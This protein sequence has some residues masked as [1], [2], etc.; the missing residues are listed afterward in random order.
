M[1]QIYVNLEELKASQ[2]DLRKT[3]TRDEEET[4]SCCS[5]KAVL[6]FLGVLSLVLLTA[7][8]TVS[9]LY[10][11]DHNQLTSYL[12]NQTAER[13]QLMIKNYN[14]TQERDQLETL[15]ETLG[16][17]SGSCPDG[18]RKFGCRCYFLSAVMTSWQQSRQ[19]CLNYGADLVIINCWDKMVFLNNLGASLK[20]WIGLR[21]ITVSY[22]SAWQWTDGTSPRT[23]YWKYGNPNVNYNYQSCAAFNSFTSSFSQKTFTTTTKS[24]SSE[25]CFQS[26]TFVCEKQSTCLS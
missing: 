6:V 12:T 4:G 20:F 13:Q 16:K 26:L 14:L 18:W 3:E 25:S 21:Q 22:S 8:I 2:G 1:D 9:V 24:W 7:V 17:S 5:L 10:G 11:L 15:V 19:Q 23:T